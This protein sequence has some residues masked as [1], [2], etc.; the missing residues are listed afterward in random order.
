MIG[1]NREKTVI[2]G[3]L[4]LLLAANVFALKPR[5]FASIIK[6][7]GFQYYGLESGNII[8]QSANLLRFYNYKYEPT[9]EFS[10]ETDQEIIVAQNGSFFAVIDRF[11]E[12]DSALGRCAT[13][14]NFRRKPVWGA[15]IYGNDSLILSPNGKYIIALEGNAGRYDYNLH[16]YHAQYEYKSIPFEYFTDLSISD[17]GRRMIVDF[18]RKGIN[19][20]SENGDVILDIDSRLYY[21]FGDSSN[22]AAFYMNG[23]IE[24]YNDSNMI[25]T[26]DFKKP[27]LYGF[28][29]S[30]DLNRIFILLRNQLI[31]IDMRTKQI[32]VQVSSDIE[33]GSF[34]SLSLA[35]AR[36][37]VAVGVDEN[38]G[39]SVI[40]EN[41]HTRGFLQVADIDYLMM[42]ELEFKYDTYSEGVPRVTFM[43]DNKTIVVELDN[44]IKL[45]D[46]N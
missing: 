14:Y 39:N 34:T 2:L 28:Q 44:E 1:N 40:K 13:I 11:S 3:L 6:E 26:H 36:K 8:A 5:E 45:I 32:V 30:E 25:W 17:D 15:I 4:A 37:V 43:D 38:K 18:G 20:I 22:I 42:E 29:V 33:H 41:R 21:C 19:L 10:A 46:L 31:S 16:L 12:A 9:T 7:S 27:R 24:V 23:I 35:S